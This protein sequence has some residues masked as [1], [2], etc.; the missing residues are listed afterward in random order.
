MVEIK[1]SFIRSRITFAI[2][3]ETAGRTQISRKISHSRKF[4]RKFESLMIMLSVHSLG[5]LSLSH[6][7]W[8]RGCRKQASWLWLALK[9]F[10]GIPSIPAALLH[11]GTLIVSM[12]SAT[13]GASLL[14]RV[15][16]LIWGRCPVYGGESSG[17]WWFRT[18]EHSSLN[19]IKFYKFSFT[20]T[21]KVIVNYTHF[22]A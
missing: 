6:A 12:I 16:V 9:N 11:G 5:K 7:S 22:F 13:L 2:I 1:G 4:F 10:A 21:R 8:M 15:L 17:R 19:L 3:F 14:I 20:F 18:E